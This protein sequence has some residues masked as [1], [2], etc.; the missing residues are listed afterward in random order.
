MIRI[1]NAFSKEM[2]LKEWMAHYGYHWIEGKEEMY[3]GL[4]GVIKAAS[5]IAD[6][7]QQGVIIHGQQS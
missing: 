1:P 3:K 5:L 2:T 6:L 4:M 7:V